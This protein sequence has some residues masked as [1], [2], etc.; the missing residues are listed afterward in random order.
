[1]GE[2]SAGMNLV[3]E[4]ESEWEED[5]DEEWWVGT[6]GVMEVRDKEEE[7]LE[8]VDETE[9]EETQFITSSGAKEDDSGLEEEIG[10]PLDALS[11]EELEEDGWWRPEPSHPSPE[12]DEEEVQYP[13]QVPGLGSQ[14]VE[15]VIERTA[16]SSREDVT[17][18]DKL[19]KKGAP[20]SRG[21]AEEAEEEGGENL[22]PGVGA[23]QAGRLVE[24]G[25]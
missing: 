25:A 3:A 18:P 16:A 11:P 14:R 17:A 5:E 21:Q 22:G 15:P 23:G 9:P 20:H 24:R 1:M 8:E 13:G 4:D 7:A 19:Q 10:Y 6:V 12:K 2:E